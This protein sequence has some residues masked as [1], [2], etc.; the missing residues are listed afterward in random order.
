MSDLATLLEEYLALRRALGYTLERASALLIDFTAY[1]ERAAAEHVTVE[2]AVAWATQTANPDSSW[3]AQRLSVV[4]CFARYLHGI[5]PRHQVPPTGLLYRGRGRP[6]P[7]LY[8]EPDVLA[9]MAA[10]RRLRSPLRAAT[11]ETLIGLLAVTGLRVGEA[12]RLDRVDVDLEHGS[13]LVRD[14]KGGDSRHVP[15]QPSTVA[16]LRRYLARRDELLPRPSSPA[17]FV[18]C[19]GTRLRH[20]NL[21]T[22][23]ARLLQQAG[24]TARPGSPKPRL[25]ALRHS[26][27]VQTLLDWYLAEG[28]VAPRLPALSTYLGHTSPSSTYW[29]LSASPPL[30]AAAASRLDHHREV[31]R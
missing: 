28:E 17:V 6:E 29:Y 31:G 18:S 23:F 9:L 1:L 15:L 10:A 3:R 12:I 8:R 11:F 13:L 7:F 19:A 5:D 27:A 4:R 24:L 14:S 2:L 20:G 25:G 16:A 21:H 22:V 26:F 30:L